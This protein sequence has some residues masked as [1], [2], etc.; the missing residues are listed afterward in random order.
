MIF[1]YDGLSKSDPA[2]MTVITHVGLNDSSYRRGW[3]SS[4]PHAPT[5]PEAG[6]GKGASA[7]LDFMVEEDESSGVEETDLQHRYRKVS[8]DARNAPKRAHKNVGWSALPTRGLYPI[9]NSQLARLAPSFAY[10][11]YNGV[12][13]VMVSGEV[14]VGSFGAATSENYGAAVFALLA[15]RV[16]RDI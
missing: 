8:A 6:R 5:V 15:V 10:S 13:V 11:E 4:P 16:A 2:L 9:E 1:R 3:P 14:E 7:P 12:L